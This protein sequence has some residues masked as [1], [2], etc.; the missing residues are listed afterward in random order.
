MGRAARGVRVGPRGGHR[1][2]ETNEVGNEQGLVARGAQNW[3][4]QRPGG[5]KRK[6]QTTGPRKI[7]KA[8]VTARAVCRA[9]SCATRMSMVE[10]PCRIHT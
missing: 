3:W 8:L 7:M 9:P 4:A 5:A 2:S 10:P 1:I 6:Q